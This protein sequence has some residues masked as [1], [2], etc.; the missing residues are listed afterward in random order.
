MTQIGKE[1]EIIIK[2]AEGTTEKNPTFINS[3]GANT[4][5]EVYNL[6]ASIF[7]NNPIYTQK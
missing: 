6:L 2:I 4:P 5:K 1:V 3:I 7:Q